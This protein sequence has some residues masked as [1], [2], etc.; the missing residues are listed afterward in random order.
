MIKFVKQKNDKL[1]PR[2]PCEHARDPLL[3]FSM[4]AMDADRRESLIMARRKVEI[5]TVIHHRVAR[6]TGATTTVE[7]TGPGSWI[8][9]EPGWMTFCLNHS[10]ICMHP[11]RELAISHASCPSGWCGDCRRI[12]EGKAPRITTGKVL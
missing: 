12:V 8:E 9:Q 7:R 5:G 6:E 10:T 3:S 11:T 2:I 4:P 1:F